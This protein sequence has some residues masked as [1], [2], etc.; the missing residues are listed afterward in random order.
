MAAPG[1]HGTIKHGVN[2]PWNWQGDNAIVVLGCCVVSPSC[3]TE[4]PLG[5]QSALQAQCHVVP[6]EL[7]QVAPL[8]GAADAGATLLPGARVCCSI[9]VPYGCMH[10]PA[11]A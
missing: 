7:L 10:V 4:L 5:Q 2:G 3:V 1:N 6:L 11:F 9:A 8:M